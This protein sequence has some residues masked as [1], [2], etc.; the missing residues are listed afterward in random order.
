MTYLFEPPTRRQSNQMEGSLRYSFT[1]SSTVWRTDGVWF[2]QE[3]PAWETLAGADIVMAGRP[4][5]IPDALAAELIAAGV[6]VCTPIQSEYVD[7]G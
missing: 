1:T 7:E 5:I 4:Q 2:H 6:G 3:T